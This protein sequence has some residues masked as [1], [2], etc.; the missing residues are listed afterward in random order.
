MRK[1]KGL[2]SRLKIQCLIAGSGMA[3]FLIGWIFLGISSVA[4]QDFDPSDPPEPGQAGGTYGPDLADFP[5]GYNP[6]TGLPVSDPA[7]L[8]LPA[9]LV[10]I[11]N[12]PV[13]ARP[14]AG[15]SF[16]PFIYEI[17]ISE[18]MTR[19]MAIFY[20]DYPISEM[21]VSGECPIRREPFVATGLVVGNYIWHDGNGDGLQSIE[22]GPISGVCV[23]LYDA[24]TDALI[25]DTSTDS[26]G[27]YG[28][29]VEADKSYY[30]KVIRP[31]GMIYTDQDVGGDDGKDS[32]ADIESGLTDIFT[33]T[34]HNM[35]WDV[36]F[37][38]DLEE[39]FPI[40][41]APEDFED[42]EEIDWHDPNEWIGQWMIRQVIG[43]IR[44]GRQPNKWILKWFY[45]GCNVD[46]GKSKDVDI[47]RCV[48]QFGDDETD[49]NSAFMGVDRL[50]EIA[51]QNK[52]DDLLDYS[53][54]V[55]SNDLPP[56]PSAGEAREVIM[57]YNFLNQ[58]KWIFDPLSGGYLRYTDWADGS[59]IFYPATDRLNGRQL[60]FHNVIILFARHEAIKPTLID[61]KLQY[62][63]G[64]AI[65]F[66]DGKAY[67]IIWNSYVDDQSRVTGRNRPIK[68]TDEGGDPV[69]L[70]PGQTWVHI[71]T[72]TTDAYEKTPAAWYVRFYAPPGAK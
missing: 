27:F 53:S 31:A 67:K 13:S 49:I 35:Q 34:D 46:A 4:A 51:E 69:P 7:N 25:D 19:W 58:A 64:P 42:I 70:H 6:L 50:K 71:V 61:I 14:Q 2:K 62:D 41:I 21:P 60:I 38:G 63:Q 65:L 56:I 43:P 11:T 22:E 28:F 3:L 68:F 1:I 10:S 26:N 72:Y 18:G 45:G 54:N 66:R 39:L 36:G 59:G 23:N 12:F 55:Y 33:V 8:E 29:N 9:V 37:K 52:P 24:D 40:N 16:A 30:I 48:V 57:F 47:P 20:G 5:P 44:S 32:D 15:P 17:F